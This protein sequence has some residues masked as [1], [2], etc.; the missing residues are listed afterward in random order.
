MKFKTDDLDDF[1]DLQS[2]YPDDGRRLRTRADHSGTPT[3]PDSIPA[4]KRETLP[5]SNWPVPVPASALGGGDAMTFQWAGYLALGFVLLLS[6]LWKGG[7]STLIGHLLR[8]MGDGGNIAGDVKPGRALIV[9]EESGGLWARRRDDLGL[10]DHCE[11]LCRPFKTRPARREWES[12]VAYLAE[13][14]SERRFNIVVVDT[15]A[16]LLPIDNENDAAQVQTALLP[17]HRITEA[18]AAVLLVHH[19]KKGDAGE[20]QAAR[21][22]GALPG[23][24]DVILELRRY[25]P[26]ERDDRRRT[27]TAYSRFDETPP[28]VV[29]ELGDDG[30]RLV[31][32]KADAKRADRMDAIGELLP[33]T[34][35]G[36]TAEEILNAWPD[37]NGVPKPGLRTARADLKHGADSGRWTVTGHGSK[38]DPLRYWVCDSIPASPRAIGA[39]M[40]SGTAD[41]VTSRVIEHLD[42]NG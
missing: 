14:V 3:G 4:P 27:L 8:A 18:G 29:I 12:F 20:G 31:G 32:G 19:P 28:E 34:A 5:E 16:G 17:L 9:S 37:G 6:G 2:R 11:F 35:P 13:L 40:E 25:A 15:I 42:A 36:L 33:G 41:P 38:G 1:S 39:G 22:S 30:Y 24:V 26:A 7:K 21:G 23:F 10:G